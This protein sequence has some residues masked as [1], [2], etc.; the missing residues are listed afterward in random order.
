M[1]R[2][3]IFIAGAEVQNNENGFTQWKKKIGIM[4]KRMMEPKIRIDVGEVIKNVLSDS[5]KIV[6][7][8]GEL[9]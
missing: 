7:S 4:I 3:I 9:Q 2:F 5:L 8:G 6:V 1:H